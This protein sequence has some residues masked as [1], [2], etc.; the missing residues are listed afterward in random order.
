MIEHPGVVPRAAEKQRVGVVGQC[1]RGFAFDQLDALDIVGR[2]ILSRRLQT[3][4][5]AFDR[6]H[7]TGLSGGLD[8]D[9]AGTGADLD[10]VVGVGQLELPERDRPDLRLRRS[11]FRVM[12]KRYACHRRTTI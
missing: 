8:R 10:E 2:E 4:W 5:L 1:L 9:R 6:R 12:W 11:G 7:A 3:L